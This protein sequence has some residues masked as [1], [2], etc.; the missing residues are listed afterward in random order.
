MPQ[1]ENVG[2]ASPSGAAFM[3]MNSEKSQCLV[4]GL[5]LVPLNF[6]SGPGMACSSVGLLG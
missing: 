1:M 6:A 3:P 2:A 4:L 5:F